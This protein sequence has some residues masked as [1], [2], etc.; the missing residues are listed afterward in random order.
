MIQ[1]TEAIVIDNNIGNM[2]WAITQAGEEAKLYISVNDINSTYAAVVVYDKGGYD[3]SSLSAIRSKDSVP[4]TLLSDSKTAVITKTTLNLNNYE[5]FFIYHKG[6]VSL[7]IGWESIIIDGLIDGLKTNEQNNMCCTPNEICHYAYAD[8]GA[9]INYGNTTNFINFGS[10]VVLAGTTDFVGIT[11]KSDNSIFIYY[12]DDTNN[13]IDGIT[14]SYPYSSFSSPFTIE[15]DA[16]TYLMMPVCKTDI[17]DNIH[18]VIMEGSDDSPDS[19]YYVN[20]SSWDT[21]YVINDDVDDDT[22]ICDIIINNTCPYV[23]C[24]GSDTDQI[25]MWSSCLLGWG[26]ANRIAKGNIFISGGS[27]SGLSASIYNDYSII[28]F[29]NGSLTSGDVGICFATLDSG[30]TNDCKVVDT[31]TD[32]DAIDLAVSANDNI[33]ILA[34]DI[35]STHEPLVLFN[36]TNYGDTFTQTTLQQDLGNIPNFGLLNM[37][38]PE[39][40]IITSVGHYLFY[41]SDPDDLVYSNFTISYVDYTDTSFTI[42]LPDGYIECLFNSTLATQNNIVCDGQTSEVPFFN[43]TNTGNIELDFS[44]FLNNGAP[45]NITTIASFDNNYV[46]YIRLNETEKVLYNNLNP[47]LSFAIWFKSNF[48]DVRY[49]EQE[50]LLNLN[51]SR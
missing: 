28:A 42:F 18:C 11:C 51:S 37:H 8:S 20:S 49:A 46:S 14:S 47:G 41:M 29:I 36:S 4:I 43:V 7:K 45:Y 44:L 32:W 23:F 38:Y 2:V 50:R 16:G 25:Q 34:S 6:S 22:D 24:I 19:A 33:L 5:S 48:S 17:N 40:N 12:Q 15:D 27:D 1:I 10:I 3:P 30:S 9:D 39:G 21:Q 35:G 31:T 13:D 26:N